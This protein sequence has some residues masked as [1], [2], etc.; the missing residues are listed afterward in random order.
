VIKASTGNTKNRIL[1]MPA[2]DP[3]MPLNPRTAAM[4]AMAIKV[5]T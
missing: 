4:M 1:A 2:A 3:V 5:M